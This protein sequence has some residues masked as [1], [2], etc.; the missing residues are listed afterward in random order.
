[1]ENTRMLDTL[2]TGKSLR[3]R[4]M[5]TEP[6][7][8][9]EKLRKRYLATKN[10]AVIDIA[11]IV[12]KVMKETEGQPIVTRRAKCFAEIVRGVPV[13][14]YP[15]E[16][17]AGWLFSEP[18][19]TEVW[20][21]QYW[22][23]REMDT[24][25]TRET[26]PFEIDE[27]AKRELK[28]EIFPYW[29]S[30][31][32]SPFIP[33]E[34]RKHGIVAATGMR[35]LPHSI[36]N[37]E[38]VLK[39]GILGIKKD[40]EERLDR[41]DLL[42]PKDLEK[43]PFLEG[44]IMGLEAATEIGRRFA[45]R[46]RE[47]ADTETDAARKAELLKIAEI[48][49][50]VPAHPARTL[51]EA[52]QSVWFA[53]IMLGWEVSAYAGM[54]PGRCDQYLYPYYER[55]I[56]EGRI[57]REDAQE[58][59]DCWCMRYSTHY[60]MWPDSPYSISNHTPAHHID[61]GGLQ[62]D[63]T[64]GANDLSYMFIEAMMHTPGMVE[65]TLGLLVHS[66][67]PDD[68]LIK[69]CQLTAVGGGYPMYINQDLMVDN[70]RVRGEISGG[71]PVT[72]ATA[73]QYGCGGGCHEPT[74][75]GME[76]GWYG[77]GGVRPGI[78]MATLPAAFELTL[79]NGMTR[80]GKERV[81]SETGDPREFESFDDFRNAYQQQLA[82]LIRTNAIAANIG[83]IAFLQPTV[84]ASALTEDCIENGV[85]KE[86]GGARYNVG[87][88]TGLTGS[89]DIG[90]SLAAVKKL[91]FD[92]RTVT[93]D[94]LLKAL[95]SNFEGYD[96][97][98][99]KCLDTAKFGND[100]DYVDEQVAWVT[101]I[102][103]EETK[104]YKTTYGGHRYAMQVPMSTYVPAGLPVGALP[105][106][107]LAG[108]PLAPAF[109]PTQGT[110]VKGP[111]AVL[112]SLGKVDNAEVSLGQTL[113]MTIDPA[114]F[115]KEDGVK[116]LADLIRTFVDQKIDQVQFNVVSADTLRGAQ[117]EPEKHRELLVKVAGYNARFT[118]LQKEIQDSIIAR[119]EHGL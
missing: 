36:A 105:S 1:M 78:R 10:K 84:F 52:L 18:G 101:H 68:L 65:P 43:V 55:D 119:T 117:K 46:A 95:G 72:L 91:V 81:G 28:E 2:E 110:D 37:Y 49:D 31:S 102:T 103:A 87:G 19:G 15:D 70:L 74:L 38:R 56:E 107:R 66:K 22:L 8:R 44:V 75:S 39:K 94:D 109:S 35:F 116:R 73:R 83:E 26:T 112:K 9:V 53:H 50:R 42:D 115:E 24:I 118:L 99:R 90:N 61:V 64:N 20:V 29:K 7:A 32:F 106:G 25:G 12:T 98:R 58:L 33:P 40:A 3:N 79:T 85:A 113:N 82:W 21:D 23:E 60:M 45:A 16:L 5:A 89:V 93:M 57:T 69:A 76:S 54:S 14:I 11:R 67:T 111:T 63:G 77:A 48:C 100:D 86:K 96:H 4:F 88:G 17:F 71:K 104:R 13:N 34:L 80:S 30:Q 92:E 59:L 51:H 41:L 114:V 47:L 97:I 62:P 27:E 108:E 6:T